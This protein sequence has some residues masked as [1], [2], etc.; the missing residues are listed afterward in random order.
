MAQA[1]RSQLFALY[2]D[3]GKC[4]E[5]RN[6]GPKLTFEMAKSMISRMRD[7]GVDPSVVRDELIALGATLKGDPV[8]ISAGSVQKWEPKP[9]VDFQAIYNEADQAGKEAAKACCP[10]P[11]VVQGHSNPLDATSPVTDRWFVP[12]GVCGFAWIKFKGNTAWARWTK[13]QGLCGEAYPSGRSIWVSAYSQSMELKE[14]Y[15]RAFAKV[16]EKHG[17]QAYAQSR[18]D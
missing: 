7:E 4:T 3:T 8:V 11:M 18:M 16:L 2:T 14:A 15:A 13:K 6:L 17:I 9:R 10:T 5:L 1:S 12:Q